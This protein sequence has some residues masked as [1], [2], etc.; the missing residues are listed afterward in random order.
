MANIIFGRASTILNNQI[1]QLANDG[2]TTQQIADEVGM[3]RGSVGARVSR[4]IAEGKLKRH[5]ERTGSVDTPKGRYFILR[6]RYNR[7]SG[8]I[9]D[10][11][12]QLPMEQAEWLCRAAPEGTNI[13]EWCAVLL[14][15]V[16]A[17]EMEE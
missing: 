17:E 13:A 1:I 10:L 8:S 14:R 2:L 4:L 15:D 12:M 11:L 9:M 6:G 16:I 7:N 3:T 5:S